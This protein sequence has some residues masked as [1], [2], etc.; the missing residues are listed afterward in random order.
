MKRLLQAGMLLCGCALGM[1]ARNA[2]KDMVFKLY[3]PLLQ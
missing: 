2:G 1:G 3:Y